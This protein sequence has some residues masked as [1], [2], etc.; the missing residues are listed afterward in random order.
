[1]YSAFLFVLRVD[2][3][4]RNKPHLKSLEREAFRAG[5]IKQGRFSYACKFEPELETN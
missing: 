3:A 5:G 4:K 1:M 2:T